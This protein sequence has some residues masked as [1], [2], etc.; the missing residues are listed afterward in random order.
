MKYNFS[1]EYRIIIEGKPIEIKN[2]LKELCNVFDKGQ[3]YSQIKE[4]VNDL[5]NII[6]PVQYTFGRYHRIYFNHDLILYVPNVS[7]EEARDFHF[8]IFKKIFDKTKEN[9]E[10]KY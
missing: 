2:W 3:S 6:D 9:Y 1:N 10:K 4:E 8:K 5:E 7:G